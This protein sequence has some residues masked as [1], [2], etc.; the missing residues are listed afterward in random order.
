MAQKIIQ[1]YAT[2]GNGI[3]EIDDNK[4]LIIYIEDVEKPINLADLLA[5]YDGCEIK[6]S[7]NYDEAYEA[8]EKF[9]VDEETEEILE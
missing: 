5:K 4:N 7:V 2:K 6:F 3:L 8:P 1:N 9:N